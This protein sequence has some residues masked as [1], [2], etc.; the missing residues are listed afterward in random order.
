M[1]VGALEFKSEGRWSRPGLCHHVV[2]LDKKLYLTFS[3]STHVF[4]WVPVT[5]CSG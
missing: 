5:Y 2:Y 4:K 3:L 1:L